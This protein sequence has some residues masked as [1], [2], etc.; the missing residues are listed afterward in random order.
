MAIETA[1]LLR[2]GRTDAS[3]PA[4]QVAAVLRAAM[5]ANLAALGDNGR[6]AT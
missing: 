5:K 2:H 3:I 6:A 1:L 4:E